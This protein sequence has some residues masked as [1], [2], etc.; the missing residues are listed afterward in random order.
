VALP[1]A[2]VQNLPLLDLI[3][4]PVRFNFTIGFAMAVL[5][6]YGAWVL[7]DWLA[8]RGPRRVAS[9]VLVGLALLLLL[10]FQWFWPMPTVEAEVPAAVQTLAEDPSLRA[11]FD[12]PWQHPLTDKDGLYL[13]TGH[14]LPM[15]GGHITRR[16]P[17]D[18]AKG[19]LLQESLDPVLLD[20]AGVDIIILHK[21]WDDDPA[22][23]AAK[24]NERFGAPL[25]DDDRIA[26][27][28]VTHDEDAATTVVQV[29]QLTGDLTGAR[30]LYV[31]TPDA[32]EATLTLTL[33]SP[34]PRT[35][36]LT[37]DGQ[38]VETPFNG[39][40]FRGEQTFT[41]PLSLG[42]G[43]HTLTLAVDP[44]CPPAPFP[45][46]ACAAVGVS[47]RLDLP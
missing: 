28:R 33:A 31:F 39:A 3:R 23:R 20:A 26:V 27:W 45:T 5:V 16:T 22:A 10:D 17:L 4:T 44:A 42:E 29:D 25:Y 40:P 32:R 35:L 21:Q 8:R 1:W 2:L 43:V 24:L 9:A 6:G 37:L 38:T 7:W 41:I 14:G 11:V 47:A 13:Q 34:T 46:L 18:P 12:V 30:S 15:I 36:R 19:M